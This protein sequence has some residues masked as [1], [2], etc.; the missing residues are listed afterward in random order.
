MSFKKLGKIFVGVLAFLSIGNLSVNA[1]DADTI[2]FNG[3]NVDYFEASGGPIYYVGADIG[4]TCNKDASFKVEY[5][6]D[7]SEYKAYTFNPEYS[8]G[9]VRCS[10]GQEIDFTD[11]GITIP[12]S[13]YLDRTESN[14]KLKVSDIDNGDFIIFSQDILYTSGYSL[15]GDGEESILDFS[16][17][18]F[19]L[20]SDMSVQKVTDPNILNKLKSYDVYKILITS[21]GKSMDYFANKYNNSLFQYEFGFKYPSSQS[22]EGKYL[23]YAYSNVFD[24]YDV[25][26]Y[27]PSDDPDLN[28]DEYDGFFSLLSTNLLPFYNG[29]YIAFKS[30]ESEAAFVPVSEKEEIV[31][32]PNT[33]A[34]VKLILFI[35]GGGLS[36][37][38]ISILGKNLSTKKN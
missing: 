3:S 35:V 2:T 37:I 34:N 28:F 21:Q 31:P 36:I 19:P 15:L 38:G 26:N 17:N 16:C 7:G 18:G 24:E 11:D 20:G 23:P 27:S 6:F 12:E 32:I 10:S 33:A 25:V 29:G 30:E 22:A 14:F 4:F 1:L 13:A 5:S 8:D 9:V